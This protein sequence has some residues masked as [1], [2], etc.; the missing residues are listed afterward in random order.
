MDS[1]YLEPPTTN[2]IVNQII[3]L[4]NKAVGHQNIQPFFLK[5]ARLVV[6]PYLKL[7]F[8]YDVF[9]QGLFPNNCKVAI[10][11]PI[12]KS[13][14][15][16]DWNYHP[17][18]ILTCFSKIIEKI[19]HARLS[20]FFK[21]HRVLYENQYRFQNNISIMHAVLVVVIS[22]YNNIDNHCYAGLAFVD[23]RKAFNTVSYETLLEKLCNYNI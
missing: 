5:S 16:A 15:K 14:A 12:H 9:T 23:F 3:S 8:N 1:I 4:T 10:V 19:L 2:K 22:S 7:F 11:T 6:A 13:Q 17:I 20:N 21:K 18:S